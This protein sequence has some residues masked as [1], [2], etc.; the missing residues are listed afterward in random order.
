MAKN[1]GGTESIRKKIAALNKIKTELPQILANDMV[2][3]FKA[4]FDKQGFEDEG[5]Q[6]WKP[7]KNVDS[8]RAILVK[9]GDLKRSIMVEFANWSKIRIKSA[10]PYSAIH[11][12]G[13]QGKA[14]GKTS[15]QMPKRK[16]MGRS[17]KLH[18]NLRD[19]MENKL[20]WVMRQK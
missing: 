11:N 9:S 10:L 15:F 4:S 1:R 13:L 3:F 16:F 8:G 5:V 6:R 17:R 12:Q 2:N 14:F 20:N 19:R 18:N 7:R